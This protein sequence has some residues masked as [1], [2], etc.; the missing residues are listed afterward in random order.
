MDQGSF[1]EHL[2]RERELRGVTLDEISTATRIATRFLQAIENEQWERLPGGVFNRG[3]VRAVARYLG[4][5]EE[6]ILAEYGQVAGERSNIP[7][8]T[9][10]P[11]AVTPEQPWLAWILAGVV[12]LTIAGGG[13]F[14]FKRV[15]AWRAARR[16]GHPAPAVA[17]P[18]PTSS[19]SPQGAS[20]EP[21]APQTALPTTLGAPAPP[22]PPDPAPVVAAIATSRTAVALKLKIEAAKT[23]Q[24]TV[25]ADDRRIFDGPITG[26][27]NREFRARQKFVVSADD[28][29]AL[30]LQLNG[31]TLAPIGPPGRAGKIVLSRVSLK[32]AA[33]GRN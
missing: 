2:K 13:W 12:M 15:V 23:T 32:G 8:W 5:D 20:A 16:V 21:A 17:A 31:E 27:E 29:G 1:G 6:D 18:S 9:G 25:E 22:D 4:L 24:V 33:G 10:S 26:G 30:V 3:F 7:V 19:T 11:P 28:S 14:A